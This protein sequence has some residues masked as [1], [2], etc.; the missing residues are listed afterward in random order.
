MQDDLFLNQHFEGVVLPTQPS[1]SWST[2]SCIWLRYVA[3]W[4]SV[5]LPVCP[6]DRSHDPRVEDVLPTYRRTK[7]LPAAQQKYNDGALSLPCNQNEE[8]KEQ[9][10]Y[11]NLLHAPCHFQW[12]WRMSLETDILLFGFPN[13]GSSLYVIMK[14]SNVKTRWFCS[15]KSGKYG[16]WWWWWGRSNISPLPSFRPPEKMWYEVTSCSVFNRLTASG[17]QVV[18]AS[19]R[20]VF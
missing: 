14:M 8:F 18:L 12:H 7:E 16:G 11:C 19:L 3:L 6:G 1:A 20:V 9:S 4:A 15:A 17:E 2:Q 13:L 5:A 10:K